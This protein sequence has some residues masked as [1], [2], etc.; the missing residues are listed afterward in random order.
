MHCC[1]LFFFFNASELLLAAQTVR[2]K[3]TKKNSPSEAES[4]LGSLIRVL[5]PSSRKST[6]ILTSLSYFFL[7]FQGGRGR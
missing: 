6:E 2:Q 4:L 7:F 3:K 5:I 1:C